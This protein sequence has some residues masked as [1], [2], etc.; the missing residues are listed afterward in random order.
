MFNGD[1]HDDWK[2]M[3]LIMLGAFLAFMFLDPLGMKGTGITYV[4]NGQTALPPG[5][6][7]LPPVVPPVVDPPAEPPPPIAGFPT[8]ETTGPKAPATTPYT[9]PVLINESNVTYDGYVFTQCIQVIG[10]NVVITNSRFVASCNGLPMVWLRE[11]INL[12]VTNSDFVGV[13]LGEGVPA[14]A[15]TCS[16][17]TVQGN[18]LRGTADG[19]DPNG[20]AQIIGNYIGQLG[21]GLT[22]GGPTHNDGF[23]IANGNG[24]VIR[25]NTINSDCGITKD[26]SG[27]AGGCNGAVF[28]QPYCAGCAIAGATIDGNYFQKWNGPV[29]TAYFVIVVDN[30]TNIT[31]QN[32]VFGNV[33]GGFCSLRNGGTIPTWNANTREDASVAAKN[34]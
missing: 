10:D 24:V 27:G 15:V 32:N 23:Q 16:S 30:S 8:Y 5:P 26:Q 1:L 11:G 25:G 21:G 2:W 7:P 14:S 6:P 4:I 20:D 31:V 13:K 9:G 28:F 3:P 19:F 29:D 33:P 17:C 22:N 34:C 18:R 12:Q